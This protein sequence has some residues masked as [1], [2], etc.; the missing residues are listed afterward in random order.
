MVVWFDAATRR[1][2]L[3]FLDRLLLNAR[4][5]RV[6]RQADR[7]SKEERGFNGPERTSKPSC[8]FCAMP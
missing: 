5:T 8:S 6:S 7:A 3:A 4:G 2:I 1:T